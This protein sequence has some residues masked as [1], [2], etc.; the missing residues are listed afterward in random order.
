[1]TATDREAPAGGLDGLLAR[2][3]LNL[4]GQLALAGSDDFDALSRAAD[5]AGALLAEAAE[6]SRR[7]TARQAARLSEIIRLHNEIGLTLAAKRREVM[8]ELVR[9]VRGRKMLKAYGG[10][11]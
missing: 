5:E 6:A 2:L 9:S 10:E 1:M 7:L 4:A 11:R 3:E 8:A